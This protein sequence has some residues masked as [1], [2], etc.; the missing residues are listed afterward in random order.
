MGP[1]QILVIGVDHPSFTGEVLAELS[2]LRAAGIVRLVDVLLVTRNDD[3]TFETLEAPAGLAASSG[4]L[5]IALLGDSNG[6]ASN[7][8]ASDVGEENADRSTI[9]TWSLADSLPTGATAAVALL[10]HLW[11]APL[12][13]AVQ[14][15]G[16]R[17]LEETWLAPDDVQVLE[18]LMTEQDR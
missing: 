8:E 9:S 2:R 16:G 10:E 12:R 7:G 15:V 3:G 4:E 14:R 17:P 18:Q 1:V 13:D 11:A 6:E 5:A